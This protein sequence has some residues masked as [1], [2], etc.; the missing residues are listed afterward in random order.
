MNI[1]RNQLI[2]FGGAT[3]LDIQAK[4]KETLNEIY[5]LNFCKNSLLT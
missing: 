1:Y 3:K 5:Q 4:F 2:V